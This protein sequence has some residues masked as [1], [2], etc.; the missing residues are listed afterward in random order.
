MSENL[1]AKQQL[2]PLEVLTNIQRLFVEARL[3]GM[4][5]MDAGRFAGMS[6]KSLSCEAYRMDKHPK[7]RAALNYILQSGKDVEITREWVTEGFKDAIRAAKDSTEMTNALREVGKLHG[8]YAPEKQITI[9]AD[10]SIDDIRQMSDK[11]LMDAGGSVKEDVEDVIDAEFEEILT[12][13]QPLDEEANG[14][15]D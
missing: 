6:E 5:P 15:K 4:P 10:A 13:V 14:E 3:N 11:E 9:N 2:T 8:L 12:A 1:P 7:V